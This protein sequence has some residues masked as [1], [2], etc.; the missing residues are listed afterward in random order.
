MYVQADGQT[1]GWRLEEAQEDRAVFGRE[2]SV[3]TEVRLARSRDS[4]GRLHCLR[5]GEVCAHSK[6][7]QRG[8]LMIGGHMIKPWLKTQNSIS[9]SSA[10]AELIAMVKLSTELLA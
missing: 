3:N 2:V 7:R 4:G 8:I 1:H 10:E 9:L 6:V 5:L